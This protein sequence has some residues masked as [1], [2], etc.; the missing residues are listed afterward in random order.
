MQEGS[1]ARALTNYCHATRKRPKDPQR[2]IQNTDT[3]QKPLLSKPSHMT[4]EDL[5]A[6]CA[7]ILHPE[8]A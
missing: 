1:F 7:L 6:K 4:G 3:R 8:A 5:H 2:K